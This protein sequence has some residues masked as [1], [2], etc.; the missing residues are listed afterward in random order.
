MVYELVMEQRLPAPIDRVFAFFERPENLEAITPGFLR[1]HIT[2]RG[3]IVMEAGATIEYRMR[4]HG[5]PIRWR[6]RIAEYD[7]PRRFVD[8]QTHGPYRMWEHEHTFEPVSGGETLMRDR[9]RYELPR[10]PGRA[11]V[12]RWL[13]RPDLER[14]FEYR[15]REIDRLIRG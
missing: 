2:T 9:V 15:R 13:V 12:H 3:P 7:P 10:G 6:T 1:F 8:V 14:I 4:L 11:L 5:V